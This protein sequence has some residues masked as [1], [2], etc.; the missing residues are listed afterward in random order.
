MGEEKRAAPQQDDATV[1][2]P[3]SL[4]KNWARHSNESKTVIGRK[5]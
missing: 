2:V 3:D 4:I 1:D 5:V